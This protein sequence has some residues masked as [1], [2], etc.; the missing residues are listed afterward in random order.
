MAG[1]SDQMI[2]PS[3]DVGMFV[4][5]KVTI[6]WYEYLIVVWFIQESIIVTRVRVVTL[7]QLVFAQC[8]FAL[9]LRE[10][11]Q[12]AYKIYV[13]EYGCTPYAIIRSLRLRSKMGP[14]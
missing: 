11:K 10:R 7:D 8:G 5:S 9:L 2:S 4:G 13:L 12:F 6:T 1:T 3:S 14:D